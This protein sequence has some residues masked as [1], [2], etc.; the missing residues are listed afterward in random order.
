MNRAES[1]TI[2]GWIDCET[3]LKCR[4]S[5]LATKEWKYYHHDFPG[6]NIIFAIEGVDTKE[7]ACE[8]GHL[9]LQFQ[10]LKEEV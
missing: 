10:L 3:G 5:P 2:I 9:L 4:R 6:T 8:V 7:E 1:A